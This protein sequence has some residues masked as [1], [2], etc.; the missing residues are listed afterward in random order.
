M[1]AGEGDLR[2]VNEERVD[3]WVTGGLQIFFDG[4]WGQVCRGLFQGRDA[5]VACRQ[6]GF[7]AGTQV[8]FDPSDYG[9]YDTEG[10]P[11]VALTSVGCTGTEATLLECAA[12][13]DVARLGMRRCASSTEPGLKLACVVSAA[14]GVP[15]R[16]GALTARPCTCTTP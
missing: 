10:T 1:A 8:V 2:L 14:A 16:P 12:D 6:L 5:D 13:A 4:A 3:N 11:E 9:D 15:W 7:G